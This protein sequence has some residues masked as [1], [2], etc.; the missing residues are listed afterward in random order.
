M[1]EDLVIGSAIVTADEIRLAFNYDPETG[2]FIRRQGRRDRLGKRADYLSS[3]H[4]YR[5]VKYKGVGYRAH[6]LA[7]VIQTG[8]WPQHQI[9]HKDLDR[10]NNSWANLRAATHGQNQSNCN[11]YKNNK[12]GLKGVSPTY[13]PLGFFRARIRKDGKEYFLGTFKTCGEAKAAYDAA[14]RELHGEFWRS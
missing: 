14:A 2:I 8:V 9:D 3:R 6:K 4:G 1:S 7:W 12:L 5:W 13:Y 10:G 11:A